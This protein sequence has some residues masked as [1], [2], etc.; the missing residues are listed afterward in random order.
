MQDPPDPPH[1]TPRR[2]APAGHDAPTSTGFVVAGQTLS[3]RYFLVRE[4]ARGGMGIVFEALDRKLDDLKLAV[5][6]LPPELAGNQAAVVRMKSEAAHALKLTH[7]HVMR[8]HGFDQEGANAFLVMEFLDGPT[9]ELELAHRGRLPLDEA[10]RLV[11]QA[12]SGLQAAHDLGIV[13]RDVKPANLMFTTRGRDRVLVVTDFGIA[14]QLKDSM[15]RLTGFDHSGTLLYAA[16]EQLQGKRPKPAADQYALAVTLYELLAGHPPFEGKGL[17][18]QIVNA[19]PEP[20]EDLDP[21]VWSVLA[22]ALAKSP[23]DRF[24]SLSDFSYALLGRPG[25]AP[26]APSPLPLATTPVPTGPAIPAPAPSPTPVP[27]AHV[28]TKPAPPIVFVLEEAEGDQEPDGSKSPDPP[29]PTSRPGALFVTPSHGR[30]WEKASPP[31]RSETPSGPEDPS[32]PPLTLGRF[33][34]LVMATLS[35][36][37]AVG[38]FL[39]RVDQFEKHQGLVRDARAGGRPSAADAPQAQASPTSVPPAPPT[40]PTVSPEAAAAARER[41]AAVRARLATKVEPPGPRFVQG[42]AFLAKGDREI[43]YRES[44]MALE[45]YQDAEAAFSEQLAEVEKVLAAK[46]AAA[47][48]TPDPVPSLA[49]TASPLGDLLGSTR[50]RFRFLL[51]RPVFR[52]VPRTHWAYADLGRAYSVLPLQDPDEFQGEGLVNR[53]ELG[54]FLGQLLV[55]CAGLRLDPSAPLE[56]DDAPSDP[57]V[58]SRLAL[59]VSEGL[60][61]G[62]DGRFLGD[63]LTT[64]YQLAVI[65]R[66]L[67]DRLGWKGAPTTR[68]LS[69]VPASHWAFDAVRIAIAAGVMGGVDE[70]GPVTFHGEKLV[71][72]YQAASFAARILDTACH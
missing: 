28:E 54:A 25:A 11:G 64:R 49:T 63:R 41:A 39:I 33:L 18:E 53:T 9:L 71:N 24:P 52:D 22:R 65:A 61:S 3:G 62:F 32:H 27:A 69:D 31:S 4:L 17:S 45:A 42:D 58:R 20:I 21:A 57:M 37:A 47:A 51:T 23:D 40:I 13:H 60:L 15:T 2:A 26:P 10:L 19:S 34:A 50:S 16:P 68:P 7:P 56:F 67:L 59:V 30:R 6:V 46:A 43:A 5:K 72:R 55:R 38:F 48:K 66:K 35:M 36:V 8:L 44:A 14:A 70:T 12:A 29:A 1:S